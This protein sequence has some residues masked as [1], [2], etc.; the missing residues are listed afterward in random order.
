[1][2]R[3]T[4]LR[5]LSEH[6]SSHLIVARP[7]ETS[8]EETARLLNLLDRL[9]D[10]MQPRGAYASTVMKVKGI[11]AIHCAFEHE[12]EAARMAGTMQAHPITRYVGWSTQAAFDLDPALASAI[13][14]ALEREGQ[15]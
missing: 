6:P 2:A 12:R 8:I 4:W 14:R 15:A 13:A 10:R 1:M 9:I 11:E 5:M 3:K 7:V